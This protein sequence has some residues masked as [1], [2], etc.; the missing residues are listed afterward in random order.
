MGLPSVHNHRY[1]L[2]I[3]DDYSRFVWIVLLKSK[4]E[5]SQHVQNFI[6]LIE[7]QFH[8]THKTL[9]TDNGPEFLFNSF[10]SSKGIIHHKS[11]VE[12][13]QQNGRV[14]RKHQHL[15]N[16]GRTLLY[17]SKLPASYWSYALLHATFII[18]RVTSP[19]LHNKSPYYHLHNHIP[20]VHTFKVFGSL[21]YYT[22]LQ[23]HRTKLATRARKFVFL[24]CSIGYKGYVLLD[25]HTR[26]IHISRNV[27]FHEHILPYPSNSSLI[28]T[29]WDYFPSVSC[30]TSISPPDISITPP[31]QPPPF[32]DPDPPH[33]DHNTSIS[34][35]SQTVLRK[36][37]RSSH[38]HVHM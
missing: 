16:V 1:F 18:N 14:E 20:D 8:I 36:S 28:A 9:R 29:N 25:I 32:I 17:Q 7:N 22:S 12:T 33:H 31:T 10:Y 21:C 38:P 19:N 4:S 2:T 5:V 26:E 35:I 6:T 34:P 15:L 23:S 11:C 13:P 30:P 3:L 24:G 27:S 37:A